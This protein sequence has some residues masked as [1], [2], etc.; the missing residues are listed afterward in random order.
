M[1]SAA[2]SSTGDSASS[3]DS[4]QSTAST[5]S[6]VHTPQSSTTSNPTLQRTSS[7]SR[8]RSR[9]RSHSRSRSP[10]QSS[11]S[12]ASSAASA[13]SSD[14]SSSDSSSSDDE[15]AYGDC[16]AYEPPIPPTLPPPHP[17]HLHHSPYAPTSSTSKVQRKVDS[18]KRKHRTSLSLS[19]WQRYSYADTF[20]AL[21]AAMFREMPLHSGR[22]G[23]GDH[24]GEAEVPFPFQESYAPPI[25][26]D[27]ASPPPPSFS[28]SEL[29]LHP[30][31]RPPLTPYLQSSFPVSV[32]VEHVHCRQLSVQRFIDDYEAP[33]IPCMIAGLT[34]H[35]NARH[36]TPASLAA[37]P[38]RNTLMKCG[39]DD[40][41]Y[42][43]K[44]KLKHFLQYM[45]AQRDDSPLYVFD[46]AFD[47]HPVARG[48]LGDFTPPPYFT[49]DLFHLV[50]E[51]KRPPYRWV[52]I[53]PERS[54]SSLH[55]DPLAT[56]AWNTLL[57]GVK[58]WVMF[59]PSAPKALVKG[60]HL[61]LKG[62]DNEAVTYFCRILPRIKEE[63]RR[64]VR[65][66]LPLLGMRETMQYPG[67]TIFV[68][69]G[70]WHAVLNLEDTIAV[71]QN[72]ASVV[73][74]PAVWRRTRGGRRRRMA[75]V[76]LKR[77]WASGKWQHLATMGVL[78]NEEDGWDGDGDGRRGKRRGGGKKRGVC[79]GGADGEKGMGSASHAEEEE[80]MSAKRKKK[81]NGA[82]ED[83]MLTV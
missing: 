74:F 12:S 37:S 5:L 50:G 67:E 55:I 20:P 71:T 54:G 11:L 51:Q 46:S 16:D 81:T 77:L 70:W 78:L 56:S 13:S 59:P 3:P 28:F 19:D 31:P 18:A 2:S 36:W 9:S 75:G 62:E 65:D 43:I 73:N 68:P 35:W 76:W 44:M 15:E 24:R 27:K 1:L 57:M 45:A 52:A 29:S 40:D 23:D 47:E 7:Q 21:K 53:G 72:Y 80:G 14:S 30:V 32:G 79:E 83:A 22:G 38:Y 8:S 4:R 48:M 41:G 34:D 61:K 42:S 66:G 49:D 10:S 39:E 6:S 82:E 17:F 63:E 33:Y 60:E 26:P 58:R 25:V 69:G 64:R